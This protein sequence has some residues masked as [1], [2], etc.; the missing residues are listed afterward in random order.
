[1]D[2]ALWD[3]FVKGSFTSCCSILMEIII[4][5]LGLEHIKTPKMTNK[6]LKMDHGSSRHDLFYMWPKASLSFVVEKT[7]VKVLKSL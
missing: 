4:V 5:P 7:P 2:L 1:M 6:T 3:Y